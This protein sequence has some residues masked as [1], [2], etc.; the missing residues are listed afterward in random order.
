MCTLSS[1]LTLTLSSERQFLL[2]AEREAESPMSICPNVSL[3]KLSMARFDHNDDD[4]G[5]DHES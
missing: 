5:D 2:S 4:H 3:L 1:E